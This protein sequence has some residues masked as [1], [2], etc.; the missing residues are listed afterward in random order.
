[1]C[2]SD[3]GFDYNPRLVRQE[4]VLRPKA[5]QFGEA[6]VSLTPSEDDPWAEVEVVKVLGAVYSVGD[7]SMLKG[8]VVA[9]TDIKGFTPYA[10]LKWD[11]DLMPC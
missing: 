11:S 9:E 2:S 5:L 7:N 8:A 10:F 6:S 3:L 4:T 1:V